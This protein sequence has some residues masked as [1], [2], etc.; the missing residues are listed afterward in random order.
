MRDD[1]DAVQFRDWILNTFARDLARDARVEKLIVN[2]VQK[3]PD[4]I[5]P[6]PPNP[7]APAPYDVL[8]AVWSKEKSPDLSDLHSRA[9]AVNLFRVDE[10]IEKNE[11]PECQGQVTQGIKN[12][13]A[14]IY[15][16]DLTAAEGLAKWDVH[17]KLGLQTHTGMKRYVRNVV[18][19]RSDGAPPIGG[20]AEVSF[21]NLEGLRTGLFPTPQDRAA[22]L[23]DIAGFVQATVSHYSEEHVVKW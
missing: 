1:E 13:P 12:L 23:A 2:I 22:F 6:P 3:A 4:F 19:A 15:R 21:A 18:T 8:V 7:L 11:L 5:P 14:L 10:I 20:I 16:P 17:A 9:A